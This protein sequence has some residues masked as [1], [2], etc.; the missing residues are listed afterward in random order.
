[1]AW[2]E[3]NPSDARRVIEKSVSAARTRM[4]VQKVRETARKSAME[5]FSLPGKLADCS[6]SNPARCEIYIVEGDSAGGCL[7]GDTQV[8]LADGRN[9]SLLEII[10]EQDAGKEHFC[11][12]IRQDGR[13]G[14]ERIIN[15]RCTKR[16]AQIVRLTLDNGETI[17]CTPDHPFMLR[18]GSYKPAADLSTDD[19][20]MPLYR[21]L[22]SK[23]EPGITID[24]YE[25]V[26]NPQSDSCLLYTSRCV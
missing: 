16:N 19:S 20:L 25:M 21:K 15:A 6:D 3:E 12:T 13:I 14:L 1:M 24:G 18:N 23:Q 10:A 26:W 9:L 2:L 8:A 17:T 4:A 5:G 11:Y 22:S 7:S